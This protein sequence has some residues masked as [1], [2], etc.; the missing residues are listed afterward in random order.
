M[1]V[2]STYIYIYTYIHTYIESRICI[3]SLGLVD[4]RRSQLCMLRMCMICIKLYVYIRIYGH[5]KKNTKHTHTQTRR[6]S[7]GVWLA[8]SDALVHMANILGKPSQGAVL[9]V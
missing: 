9:F 8:H 5:T 2:Y 7:F 1:Y 6:D 3:E 4:V